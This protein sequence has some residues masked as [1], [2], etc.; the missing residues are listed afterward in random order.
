[1]PDEQVADEL[2]HSAARAQARGGFAAAAAFLE[3]AA[4]LT[5]APARRAQRALGRGSDEVPGRRARRR[6]RSALVS[7]R[8]ARSTNSIARE[9]TCSARRSHSPQRTAEM[10][11]GCCSAPPAGSRHCHRRSPVRPISRLCRRRCS[12][13][14]WRRRA[15]ARSTWRWPRRPRRGRASSA[16][17]SCGS[18]DSRRCSPTA[19]RRPF[20]SCAGRTGGS[21]VAT[22]PRVSKCVGSGSR[23]SCP[24]TCGTTSAGKRSPKR[25]CRSPGRPVRSASFRS[26]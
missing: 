25:T 10:R 19:T 6:A 11:L 9:S 15:H 12:R 3:R 21:T 7:A 8:S 16:A 17:S 4:M 14:G 1:M 13:D 26:L 18:T 5:P 23:P 22:C 24:S 20:R 2:E